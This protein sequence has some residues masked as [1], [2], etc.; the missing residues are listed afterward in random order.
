[1]S[2]APARP[3]VTSKAMLGAVLTVQRRGT[4]AALQQLEHAEPDLAEYVMESLAQVHRAMLNLGG[5]A[6]PT[7]AAYRQAELTTLACIEAL[8]QSPTR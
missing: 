1:M 6:K 5:P 7:Q 8:R 4:A 2:R 3:R